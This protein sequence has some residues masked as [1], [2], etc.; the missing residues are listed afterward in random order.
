MKIIVTGAEDAG[1]PEE[2]IKNSEKLLEWRIK[3]LPKIGDEVD[4]LYSEKDPL[5]ES[6]EL[7]DEAY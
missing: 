2:M 6:N 3:E 5:M 7:D 1:M 4:V